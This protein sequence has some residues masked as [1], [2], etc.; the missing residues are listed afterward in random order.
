MSTA[1][2]L[3][4]SDFQPDLAG[5]ATATATGA[6]KLSS[7]FRI[8]DNMSPDKNEEVCVSNGFPKFSDIIDLPTVRPARAES[9]IDA[10]PESE[11]LTPKE[12]LENFVKNAVLNSDEQRI[13]S[14]L[15]GMVRQ[16]VNYSLDAKQ[17]T[18]SIQRMIANAKE[19]VDFG[20][21]VVLMNDRLKKSE[22]KYASV[23]LQIVNGKEVFA[24]ISRGETVLK[25]PLQA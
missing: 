1:A 8:L 19:P 17:V 2:N 20:K 14:G 18:N 7:P 22:F 13:L 25:A 23:A 21:I 4:P 5:L 24:V 3:A 10:K 16:A 11:L 15:N 12:A 6:L 9:K